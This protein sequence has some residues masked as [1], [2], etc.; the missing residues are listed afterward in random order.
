MSDKWTTDDMPSLDGKIAIVTGANSGLGYYTTRELARRG[1]R[2]VMACRSIDRAQAARDDISSELDTPSI[3]IMELDLADLSSVREFADA[4]EAKFDKLDL[5]INNAGIMAIPRRE[6]ADGFEMQIG[7]NH[8]GH[9]AL[10]GHLLDML[11]DADGEARVVNVSSGAHQGGDI[12]FDDLHWRQTYSKWGAYAQSKLANLLFTYEL[13]RRLD[14][15]DDD[16]KSTAAHPGYAA[17]NLQM[18]G[19]DMEGSSIKR[20]LM[21]LANDFVAQSAEMGALPT[22]YAAT[23]DAVQGGDY[24]GPDGFMEIKGHPTKVESNKKS[25]DSER[26]RRLWELSQRETGVELDLPTPSRAAA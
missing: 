7:V 14:A 19:P 16:I 4:F 3:D 6:T 8:L 18:A 22:L 9:F 5:L 21:E 25:N 13:Q 11:R 1:A 24:I 17:T 20:K 10:T 26:A 23:A 15:A 12:R 2:T